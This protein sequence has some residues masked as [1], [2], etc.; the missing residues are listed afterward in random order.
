[1]KK[2][3]G[4]LEQEIMTALNFFK[5]PEDT[6]NAK[7]VYFRHWGSNV[8]EKIF[9]SPDILKSGK[10]MNLIFQFNSA[11]VNEY[12][13]LCSCASQTADFD[14]EFT[15]FIDDL[16]WRVFNGLMTQDQMEEEIKKFVASYK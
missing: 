13:F 9:V 2:S 8:E 10:I 4:E 7:I 12:Q 15:P 14:D 16:Q 3:I 11:C 5:V 1:M 6:M